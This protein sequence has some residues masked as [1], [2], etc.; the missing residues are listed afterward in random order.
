M[1]RC[2]YNK[3][4]VRDMSKTDLMVRFTGEDGNVFH[5]MALV[6]KAL[7]RNGQPELAKEVAD[8]LWEQPDYASALALFGEYVNI[9]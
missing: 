7:E 4:E 1:V 6:G 2:T 5:L 9:V 3:K 8:K